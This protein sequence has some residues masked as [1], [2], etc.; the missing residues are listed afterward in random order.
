[1]NWLFQPYPYRR[2]A[3]IRALRYSLGEG[4]FL[5]LFLLLFE[6]FGIQHWDVPHK[7]EH[8]AGFGAMTAL[9]T[10]LYRIP[11]PLIFPRFF[12]EKTW[13]VWKEIVGIFSL[14]GIITGLNL[15]YGSWFFHWHYSIWGMFQFYSYVLAIAFFPVV[16]WTLLD[17]TYQLK[18]YS[19]EVELGNIPTKT[20]EIVTLTDE[21]DR[22]QWIFPISAIWALESSDNYC[23]VYFEEEGNAKQVLIRS[24]LV[25]IERQLEPYPAFQRC[26]RSYLANFSRVSQVKGNAQGYF[27]HLT[28]TDLVIPV[29][30]KYAGLVETLKKK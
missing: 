1:M 20:A 19:Q 22:N 27:L 8:L 30:R 15:V 16:F 13:V 3:S 24:S 5:F 4:L 2:R 28:G 12:Q 23:T 11:L 10:L 14:V 7:I 29:A 26:H 9:G 21:F 17:Y 6:P 25:R 18:K